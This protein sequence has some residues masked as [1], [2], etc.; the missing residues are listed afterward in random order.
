MPASQ[1]PAHPKKP[2]SMPPIMEPDS[3]LEVMPEPDSMA[4][5][6]PKKPPSMPSITEP[7]PALETLQESVT[8]ERLVPSARK[9]PSMPPIVELS[10]SQ[11][12]LN[13]LSPSQEPMNDDESPTTPTSES[14]LSHSPGSGMSRSPGSGS[15]GRRLL[16]PSLGSSPHGVAAAGISSNVAATIAAMEQVNAELAEA[17]AA[18]KLASPSRR[19]SDVKDEPEHEK[20]TAVATPT[21]GQATTAAGSSPV[22]SSQV[23]AAGL[24]PPLGDWIESVGHFFTR[25][26]QPAS[27][28]VSSPT[29]AALACLSNPK[30]R[31]EAEETAD[32]PARIPLPRPPPRRLYP[33]PPTGPPDGAPPTNDFLEA[34]RRLNSHSPRSPRSP[35]HS[36]RSP[37]VASADPTSVDDGTS[38]HGGTPP[39]KGAELFISM[40]SS[41]KR[42]PPTPGSPFEAAPTHAGL[43]QLKFPTPPKAPPN[44]KAPPK[45]PPKTP[46]KTPPPKDGSS[47]AGDEQR[48]QGTALWL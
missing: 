37:S 19:M 30:A 36:P 22:K 16:P 31:E 11:E 34:R 48:P 35:R 18:A 15:R 27:A 17:V 40:R 28:G 20:G 8:P 43:G 9:G 42:T 6:S 7:D 21:R 46:P 14:R 44:L 29:T 23:Q 5:T 12:L 25:L 3:S 24:S 26:G 45:A 13:D 1:L 41:L 2:P 32:P 33:L 10:P 38:V 39:L 4:S 47:S